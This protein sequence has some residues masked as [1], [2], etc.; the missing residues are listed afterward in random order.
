[1]FDNLRCTFDSFL[2]R[3]FFVPTLCS[4]LLS[5]SV[6]KIF[7]IKKIQSHTHTHTHTCLWQHVLCEAKDRYED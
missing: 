4:V 3:P 6:T 7:L 2:I 1:M 5:P